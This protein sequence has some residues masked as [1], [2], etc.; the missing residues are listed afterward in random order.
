MPSVGIGIGYQVGKG[1]SL[2]I[3]HKTT[4]TMA[5]NFDGH[6]QA[7]GKYANDWYHYT[8][9]LLYTSRCV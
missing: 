7:K 3:E 4:F 6:V 9:C 2:G 1:V 8:S 5:D